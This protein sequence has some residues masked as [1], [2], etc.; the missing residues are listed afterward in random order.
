M[1]VALFAVAKADTCTGNVF[2]GFV[3]DGTTG[4]PIA[5]QVVIEYTDITGS[6]AYFATKR[7]TSQ[8]TY[9][10]TQP[11][12]GAVFIRPEQKYG[13][14]YFSPSSQYGFFTTSTTVNWHFDWFQ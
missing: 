6:P 8:G 14:G 3:L 12:C 2:Q 1:S 10:W 7:I 9:S 5:G 13:L 11:F 4:T